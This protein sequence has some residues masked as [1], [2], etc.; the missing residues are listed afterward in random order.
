MSK[1]PSLIFLAV[2]LLSAPSYAEEDSPSYLS[3]SHENDNLG[4]GTDRY[5]TSGAR[6]T[7]FNAGIDVPPGID[8]LA[9]HIPTFDLNETTSTFYTI[10]QNLYT[11][12]NIRLAAQPEDDR[13]WAGF[14]YGSVGLATV[15]ENTNLPSH[16][17]E[18]EFTLGIIGEEAMGEETQKFVHKYI[19]NSPEPQGWDNQLHFEPVFAMSW[20][21][22]IPYAMTFDSKYLNA[23]IEPNFSVSL[24][25]LRT[26]AGAGAMLILGSSQNIDTPPR[27]RP[28]PPGT[29]V[30][31][32]EKDELN[33][34]VFAGVDARLVGRDVFLDGNTFRDSHSVDKKPLVGDAT[35]GVSLTYSDYRVSYTLNARSKEFDGQ[36]EESVFGSLTLTKRF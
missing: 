32:T 22:R 1:I 27:V 7:W 33:W 36:E 3:F 5:Y 9:E 13:P 4:G 14:L 25:T 19:S 8:E 30:F 29:G 15:T 28:A 34:Q 18:L 2:L 10:G 31:F 20:Q 6:A 24:G 35:A 23:R 12:A 26:Y 16:V 21:R 11:P 17:D